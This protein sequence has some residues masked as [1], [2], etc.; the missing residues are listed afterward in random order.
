MKYQKERERERKKKYRGINRRK[1]ALLSDCNSKNFKSSTTLPYFQKI[2]FFRGVA[3]NKNKRIKCFNNSFPRG[4]KYVTINLHDLEGFSNPSFL[5]LSQW[6]RAPEIK[7]E[8]KLFRNIE[9]YLNERAK[10]LHQE[11]DRVDLDAF[12]IG[13]HFL[14]TALLFWNTH[15]RKRKITHPSVLGKRVFS[16]C[17]LEFVPKVKTKLRF[18]FSIPLSFL[19]FPPFFSFPDFQQKGHLLPRPR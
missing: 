1:F 14:E 16:K 17:S 4:L 10:I 12:T 11:S 9:I 3:W 13:A 15:Y 6:K 19:L 18:F 5:F 8:V 7:I 2:N